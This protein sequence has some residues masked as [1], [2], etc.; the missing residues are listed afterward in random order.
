M[1]IDFNINSIRQKIPALILTILILGVFA[2]IGD[3]TPPRTISATPAHAAAPISPFL[4]F[5]G[6]VFNVIY[7]TCSA[8]A[9][10]QVGPPRGGF[11]IFQPG[12]TRVYRWFQIPRAGVWVLGNYIPSG[13]CLIFAG[14]SCVPFPAQGTI[15][16]V[17]TSL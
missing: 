8:N 17:G 16:I 12:F 2:F 6:F 11:F 1:K 4:P 9:V 15:T 14:K 5:G 3:T 13:T 10:L 7:C